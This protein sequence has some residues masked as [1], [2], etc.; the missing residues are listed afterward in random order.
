MCACVS[1]CVCGRE[2]TWTGPCA[3]QCGLSPLTF[4][5]REAVS[6]CAPSRT[7]PLLARQ[8]LVHGQGTSP[9]PFPVHLWGGRVTCFWYFPA[10]TKQLL[11]PSTSHGACPAVTSRARGVVSDPGDRALVRPCPAAGRRVTPG[12]GGDR[13]AGS[14]VSNLL[15]FFL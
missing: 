6:P 2:C 15:F 14:A 9:L 5:F 12:A 11:F 4:R 10:R 3:Q 7:R 1:K 13:R 8:W